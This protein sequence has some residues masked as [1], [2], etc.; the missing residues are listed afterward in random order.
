MTRR[1]GQAGKMIEDL[2]SLEFNPELLARTGRSEMIFDILQGSKGHIVD[3]YGI[4]NTPREGNT[5]ENS[6]RRQVK[7]I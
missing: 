4:P 3:T 7:I 5:K 6:I 1:I 2:G